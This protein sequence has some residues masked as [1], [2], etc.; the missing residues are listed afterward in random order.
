MFPQTNTICKTNQ[1]VPTPQQT[2]DK[3]HPGSDENIFELCK[4]GWQ[5]NLNGTQCHC[6]GT[7]CTNDH[8]KEKYITVSGLC[9]HKQQSNNHIQGKQHGLS[10]AQQCLLFKWATS[11]MQGRGHF[12]ISSNTTSGQWWHNPQ[13]SSG[14]QSSDVV[15]GKSWIGGVIHQCKISD[16]YLAKA[17]QNGPPTASDAKTNR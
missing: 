17:Q 3:I 13:H 16:P 8:N 10:C 11:K 5:H 14:H 9:H 4:G 2:T 15:S 6:N 12:F 7:S 1:Q